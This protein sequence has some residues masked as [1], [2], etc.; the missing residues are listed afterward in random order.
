MNIKLVAE[1]TFNLLKGFGY[2]VSSYDKA[3][4]LVIDPMEATRFAVESPNIL[5]RIDPLDKHLSLKT[6]TPGEAI[7]KIRPMLKELAQDYLLDFDYSVFDKQ[8]KPKGEK[9]DVAKNENKEEDP[10]SEEINIIKKLAGLQENPLMD[11]PG[12][13]FKFGQDRGE[14]LP[15][16][17][18]DT[19]TMVSNAMMDIAEF[20]GAI[21]NAHKKGQLV[22]PNDQP[23][24]ELDSK[25]LALAYDFHKK[26]EKDPISAYAQATAKQSMSY[27]SGDFSEQDTMDMERPSLDTNLPSDYFSKLAQVKKTV[28]TKYGDNDRVNGVLDRLN[29]EEKAKGQKADPNNIMMKVAQHLGESITEAS[30][31]K[32]TG[33]R[34]SS[35]QPLADS[36]KIIVRHNKDVNEEVRG[37]RSRNIHSILIQR[38]EEKFKMAENNLQAARAMARHLHNGGETFD[39]IGEAITEMSREFRTLKEFVQY[40]RRAKLVNEANEEFVTLAMENIKTIKN[41][42][43]RLSGVKSYANAVESVHNYNNV[44][45]LE[46]DLDLES[47]FTETHFDDKVANA[48]ENLKAM[49][50]RQRSFE[51]KIMK[52]IE[53]ETFSGLKDIISEDELL[54]FEGL[55]QQL[56]HRVHALSSTAKDESLGKY[57]HS[58][59]D[60]LNAGGQLSQFEYGAIKSCLLSAGQHNVPNAPMSVEESYEAFMDRFDV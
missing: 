52:A 2:E 18:S 5:V 12:S 3:G 51:S 57:L 54:E 21:G 35:Y 34:K 37:A 11:P 59:S 26:G 23:I 42:F 55:N 48:M 41:T 19:Q 33:S 7:E 43:H 17:P 40:V 60:K 24:R 20:Y 39:E 10:M 16:S 22:G 44:E 45:I 36:V 56:G 31:G 25:T 13:K 8:I 30:L 28:H 49:T 50:S 27:M 46:D 53:S 1:K 38:G 4:D 32:M 29:N 47:K 6:G 9:L 14:K 15:Q 58:I